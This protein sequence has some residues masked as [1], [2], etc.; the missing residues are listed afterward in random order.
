MIL[1]THLFIKDP[2]TG[3]FVTEPIQGNRM[4]WLLLEIVAFYMYMLSQMLFIFIR[5]MQSICTKPDA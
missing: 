3:L 2:K 4:S 5:S 1:V